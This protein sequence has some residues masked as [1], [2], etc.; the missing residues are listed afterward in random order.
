MPCGEGRGKASQ[1]RPC[2]ELQGGGLT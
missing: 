1:P 2:G